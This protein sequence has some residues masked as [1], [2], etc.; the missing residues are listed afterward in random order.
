MVTGQD[1]MFEVHTRGGETFYCR[2]VI[3]A[4]G[5]QGNLRPLGVPGED[6]ERVQYQLDDPDEYNG[7]TIAV[8]GAGERRDRERDRARRP[9]PRDPHQPQRG[10]RALQGGQPLPR[11]G[12][13]Q[14]SA[15]GASLRRTSALKVEAAAAADAAARL[16]RQDAGGADVI[17]CHRI[18][19][20]LG[21]VPPRKL[22]ESFG[23]VFP[24]KDPN[25]M[26]TRTSTSRT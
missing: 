11:D 19:A 3:L 5:L 23:V 2:K 24:S 8:V 25:S 7:E 26:P 12:G 4:I 17:E 10:V 16:Q 1:G 21:A 20:R 6:L 15:S 22:V 14:R 9:Q 13:H 18:I